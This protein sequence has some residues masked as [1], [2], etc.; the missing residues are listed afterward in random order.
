MKKIIVIFFLILFSFQASAENIAEKIKS[1]NELYKS[2]AITKD[3][4]NKKKNSAN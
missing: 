4:Y 3:Q 2:G 1:L